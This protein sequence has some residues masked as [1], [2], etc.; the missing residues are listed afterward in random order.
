MASCEVAIDLGAHGPVTASSL[1]C[2]TGTYAV[3]EARRLILAGE[4]DVVIAGGADAG[5]NEAVFAGLSNMGPLS[6]NNDDP[7]GRQPPLRLR[8]R[9]LR[10]RRGRGGDG[11]RVGRACRGA[12]RHLIR[13]VAG[14]ALTS[15]AFHMSAPEPSGD[16]ASGAIRAR[17]RAR[18]HRPGGAR[19]HLRPRHRDPRQRRL[20][21]ARD[22][23]RPRRRHRQHPG[24][25]AEVDGRPPDR[26]RRRL[27]RDGLP[28]RRCA[29]ASCRRRSTSPIR[30]PTATSTTSPSPPAS[31]TATSIANAF[32]FGG[33][34]CVVAFRR[35]QSIDPRRRAGRLPRGKGSGLRHWG[36]RV[37]GVSGARP[38][39]AVAASETPGT[40][41]S[42][43][44]SVTEGREARHRERPESV[45]VT[46]TS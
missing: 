23:R 40:G 35:P 3:L 7:A 25:L 27:R 37:P 44:G 26:R 16:Y 31:S 43:G 34:N 24:L 45:R 17:P 6:E 2:A 38:G 19:L 4:A 12:R 28:A 9:R 46:C 39:Q 42:S 36:H 41:G 30:T 1:A 10:L 20:R 21:V 8:P 13:E 32:G 14:G 29:T 33:Q 15:D 22:P 11:D 5:I 18:R